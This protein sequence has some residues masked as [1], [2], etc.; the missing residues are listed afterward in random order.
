VFGQS[1]LHAKNVAFIVV[2][3]TFQRRNDGRLQH[4][5]RI[6]LRAVDARQCLRDVL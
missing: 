3:E 5:F 6:V 1:L 4:R 2:H